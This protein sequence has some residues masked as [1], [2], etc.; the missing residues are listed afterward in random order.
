M[1][2]APPLAAARG[3][4]R[5]GVWDPFPPKEKRKMRAQMEPSRPGAADACRVVPHPSPPPAPHRRDVTA[6][7]Q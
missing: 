7:S 4:G 5:G 3:R 6:L 2:S 1:P